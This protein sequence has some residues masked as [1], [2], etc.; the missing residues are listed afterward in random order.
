M[1]AGSYKS[2]MYLPDFCG[3]VVQARIKGGYSP[4]SSYS[5]QILYKLLCDSFVAKRSTNAIIS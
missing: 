2:R 3:M 5:R 1:I 4:G